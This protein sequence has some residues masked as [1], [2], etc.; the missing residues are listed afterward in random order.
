ME[1][2]AC[3]AVGV[4]EAHDIRSPGLE[5]L[6]D[7]QLVQT[8][9]L[10]EVGLAVDEGDGDLLAVQPLGQASGGDGSGV[11]GS[12]DDDSV[13]HFPAPVSLGFAT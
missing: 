1:S 10:D 6:A 5:V 2:A 12:E 7:R 3:H 13:L 9:A 11:S 4:P 8:D